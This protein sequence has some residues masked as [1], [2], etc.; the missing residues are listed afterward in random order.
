VT[1]PAVFE[2]LPHA[3]RSATSATAEITTAR[4]AIMRFPSFDFGV[5]DRS[6]PSRE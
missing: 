2:S 3:P 4:F 1:E 6:A 5:P